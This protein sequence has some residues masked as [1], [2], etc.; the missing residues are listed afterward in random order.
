MNVALRL[1]PAPDLGRQSQGAIRTG[2]FSHIE[3]ID[4][5]SLAEPIWR[6][7]EREDALATPY[8]SFNLLSGWQRHVGQKNGVTPFIVVGIDAGGKPA[9]LWPLGR[10]RKGPLNV[11]SF[12]GGK[13]S[14][15][16]L[17]LWR[18]DLVK[19][20]NADD[21]RA[22][23]AQIAAA[24]Y[25]VDVFNLQ[26]QPLSWEGIV[27]PLTLLPHQPSPS[28]GVRLKLSAPGETLIKTVLSPAMRGRLRTKERR[29][30]R[31]K[32]YRYIQATTPAE[33]DRLLD[34]FFSL[35]AAH[36]A[37][38]ALPNIFAEPGNEAFLREACHHGLSTGHP[39][40]ELHALEGDGEMLAL[41][42]GINDGRRFS[43]MFNTYTMSDNARQSPGLVL[44]I[45]VITNLADRGMQSFDL[46]VGE[47]RYKS[48]F[49]KEPEPLF[50]SFLPLTPL[51]RIAAISGRIGYRM[52]RHIKHSRALWNLVGRFRHGLR[53][54]DTQQATQQDT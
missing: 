17:G 5:L 1:E 22:V 9:F 10:L 3:I 35:K 6:R 49:C 18:R 8:Q 26:S 7:L 20:F 32:G 51:G 45:H 33:I 38:Q 2:R 27:N 34:A 15:F 13:H 50:D 24:R 42:A 37:A 54:Q 11:A 16:N 19:S 28:D 14:N 25:E 46:G 47:A 30:Q 52:K 21:I 29:L 12:L 36:M 4:D 31:L 53:G 23:M 40:I 39:L 48:F 41:F 43:G 44:L